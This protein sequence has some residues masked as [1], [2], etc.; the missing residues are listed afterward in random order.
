MSCLFSQEYAYFRSVFYMFFGNF[1]PQSLDRLMSLFLFIYF[2][3]MLSL[4]QETDFSN[5]RHVQF[6]HTPFHYCTFA[7]KSAVSGVLG[8][9][10]KLTHSEQCARYSK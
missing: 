3:V 8:G 1:E 7:N 6:L 4:A 10:L 5:I 9:P 2:A